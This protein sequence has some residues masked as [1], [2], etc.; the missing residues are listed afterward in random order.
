MTDDLIKKAAAAPPIPDLRR[1]AE[2]KW[3]PAAVRRVMTDAANQLEKLRE[4]VI[5]NS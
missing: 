4:A 3:I 2:K 1:Y 5:R